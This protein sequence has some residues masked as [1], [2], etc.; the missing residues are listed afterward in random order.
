MQIDW[1]RM[2]GKYPVVINLPSYDERKDR[3]FPMVTLCIRFSNL[4][5]SEVS[6]Q[7]VIPQYAKTIMGVYA[8]TGY[9]TTIVSDYFGRD[10]YLL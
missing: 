10:T 1:S 9:C 4:D 5:E 8:S 7:L 2:R 3:P 6:G